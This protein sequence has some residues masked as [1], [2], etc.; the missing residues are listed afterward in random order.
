MTS[1]LSL[2]EGEANPL[3]LVPCLDPSG[4]CCS[5]GQLRGIPFWFVRTS[6]SPVLS[7]GRVVVICPKQGV[8]FLGARGVPFLWQST[9]RPYRLLT[10]LPVFRLQRWHSSS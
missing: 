7:I 5:P 1:H 2:F 3:H 10:S 4:S 6:I 8:P 9:Y